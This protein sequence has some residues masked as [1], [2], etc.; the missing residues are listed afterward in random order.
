MILENTLV[1]NA[2][3]STLLAEVFKH[4]NRVLS[5]SSLN[6]DLSANAGFAGKS[7]KD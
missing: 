4:S 3:E 5:V 6:R 1:G 2:D 7:Y